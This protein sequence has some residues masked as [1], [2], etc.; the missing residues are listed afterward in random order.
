VLILAL[1]GLPKAVRRWAVGD[2][3][4]AAWIAATAALLYAPVPLQRRLVMG[5]HFPLCF[6]AAQGLRRLGRR[7]P[8]RW[9]TLVSTTV[10]L[11]ALTNLFLLLGSL[12]AVRSGDPRLF[13]HRDEVPALA[14]LRDHAPAEALALAAPQT[15]LLIPAWAGQRVIYG[16][17]FETIHADERKSLVTGFFTSPAGAEQVLDAFPVNYVFFG[18]RER[19]LGDW[20]ESAGWPVAYRNDSVTIFGLR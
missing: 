6:L 5:L 7:W 17:P 12:A 3:L 14:W 16:H 15:G 1:V 20:V 11:S 10:G 18:P 8:T 9:G 2:R 13:L 4:S 19:V